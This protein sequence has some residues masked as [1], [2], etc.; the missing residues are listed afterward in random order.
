MAVTIPPKTIHQVITKMPMDKDDYMAT[1]IE[2]AM[3]NF[4]FSL[5]SQDKF[6]RKVR[7]AMYDL[8]VHDRKQMIERQVKADEIRAKAQTTIA[9]NLKVKA[10][11]CQL[12]TV[13]K[14]PNH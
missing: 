4:S 13:A 14:F 7:E 11:Y 5:A 3:G 10:V 1:L 2:R 6:R 12:T 9:K 8:L